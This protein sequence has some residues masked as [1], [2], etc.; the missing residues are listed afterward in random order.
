MVVPMLEMAENRWNST[1][2]TLWN[3]FVRKG[4]RTLR[5]GS[6]WVA[7]GL[8]TWFFAQRL[9]SRFYGA[10]GLALLCLLAS[11]A[12]AEKKHLEFT[13][14]GERVFVLDVDGQK[15]IA[16][17][18][19]SLEPKTGVEA[20][21]LNDT[22][23]NRAS[24]YS[25]GNEA[26]PWRRI[27]A[28]P[29]LFQALH[30]FPGPG[31]GAYLQDAINPRLCLYDTS[32]QWLSCRDL[33]EEMQDQRSDRILVTPRRDG[34]FVF[35][36]T[37]RGKASTWRESHAGQS[38]NQWQKLVTAKVQVGFIQCW[39]YPWYKGL[40][41]DAPGKTQ[42]FD[43]F[44]NVLPKGGDSVVQSSPQASI[45]RNAKGEAVG[46]RFTRPWIDS[47]AW[48]FT[49]SQGLAPCSHPAP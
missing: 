3:G 19:N 14:S 42:C 8:R 33:P 6:D 13:L 34:T 44:L 10:W 15:W 20:I 26:T 17:H 37:D 9:G 36:D 24:S 40:C 7:Q 4:L 43:A 25:S 22:D 28:P 23:R 31:G 12:A 48:C 35:I 18:L 21:A 47:L 29:G 2:I 38:H 46:Y 30:L 41:C 11:E 49:T 5:K 39:E 16:G 32:G 1:K 45:L 27:P